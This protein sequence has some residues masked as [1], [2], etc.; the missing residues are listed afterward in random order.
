MKILRLILAAV[1][2]AA[3]AF[4]GSQYQTPA[5]TVAIVDQTSSCLG[6][7]TV[8]CFVPLPSTLNQIT[9]SADGMVYG[10]SSTGSGAVYS[11]TRST[12]T[13]AGS[14]VAS[15][16]PAVRQI[17]VQSRST[18]Y[19]L[20]LSQGICQAGFYPVLKANAALNAWVQLSPTG[21]LQSLVVSSDGTVGGVSWGTVY[22]LEPGGT[23][24]TGPWQTSNGFITKV[25]IQNKNTAF[26]T[27]TGG[28]ILQVNI[29]TGAFTVVSG[30][31]TVS[32][33]FVDGAGVMWIIA[34]T[35]GWG[36][37]NVYSANVNGAVIDTLVPYRG[38]LTSIS[39]A[40]V[41][42]TVGLNGSN[43]YHFNQFVPYVTQSLTGKYDCS[44]FPPNGQCPTGSSH[45][46]TVEIRFG[47][48]TPNFYN[49]VQQTGP[50]AQTFNLMA[51]DTGSECDMFF[52]NQKGT[53]C[54][55]IKS[56]AQ[57]I[58]NIMGMIVVNAP[59]FT[60]DFSEAWT[61]TRRTGF[62]IP[63]SCSGAFAFTRCN[64]PVAAYCDAAS[65]PPNYNPFAAR[66][67]E[68]LGQIAWGWLVESSCVSIHTVQGTWTPWLCDPHP[69]PPE[70]SAPGAPGYCTKTTP[71]Q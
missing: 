60:F 40:A 39:A 45:T 71:G 38:F 46:G 13:V 50:P 15:S 48:H 22:F 47:N 5:P 51:K 43:P 34:G 55:I 63:G 52:G 11:M 25:V 36:N 70:L 69:A 58:C 42:V 59:Q 19:A 12:P 65:T 31:P 7:A 44:T 8:N 16:L 35:N 61:M 49:A 9:T 10:L 18:I 32:D 23:S 17:A 64:F 37:G 2:L 67:Y 21:C 68:L 66:D 1:L 57:V 26:V 62:E 4:A 3:P 33:F 53:T 29:L 41:G 14:W 28:Q 24:W 56:T 27:V 54:S 6:S 20:S 30:L